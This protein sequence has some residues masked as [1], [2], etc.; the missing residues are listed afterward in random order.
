M[1]Q[2]LKPL[3]LGTSAINTILENNFVYIDKT[4]IIYDM[5]K[6]PNKFF[7]S[8][9]RRFGKSTLLSTINEIFAGNKELFKEQWIYTSP[10]D[11]QTYPI[12]RLDFNI[13]P[14]ADLRYYIKKCLKHVALQYGVF[15]EKS[16]ELDS[17]GIYFRELIIN[18]QAKYKQQV[19]ILVDEYDKPILDVINNMDEAKAKR[20]ILKGLYTIIKGV[21]EKIRFVFLTGV[22]RFSK[23]GIFSGLNNLTDITLSGHY[24]TLCGITQ[25]ELLTYFSHYIEQAAQYLHIDNRSCLEQIKLWYNGFTFATNCVSVYNPYSTMLFLQNKEFNNYWFSSGNPLFLIKL[26]MKN[27]YYL[28]NLQQTSVEPIFFDSFDIDQI[29]LTILLLQTGYL[30]IC[31]T[32]PIK[33]VG[34]KNAIWLTMPNY[35]ISM[36]LNAHILQYIYNSGIIPSTINQTFIKGVLKDELEYFKTSIISLFANIP[37]NWYT[38]NN[39]AHYEGFYCSLFYAFVV[40]MGYNVIAE[41]TTNHGR[42]DLTLIIQN[43]VYIFELKSQ[44]QI[45]NKNTA[46]EQ[47]KSKNYAQKYIGQGY[48]KIYLIGIEFNEKERNLVDFRYE[49]IPSIG[50]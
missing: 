35:E 13:E 16:Y 24:S 43:K 36:S 38:N 25:E 20:E 47:I 29:E 14:D 18:L 45:K 49:Y 32:Q 40:G 33:I 27:R 9:P 37:H 21:D 50:T 19:V 3:P 31:Q 2:E 5:I 44:N 28:P 15:E 34:Y 8:R 17:Y 1:P 39:I 10:W 30:T 12:I 41:D 11:W 48:A 22:T 7:L 42:I 26:L 6:N 46:L 23:V 4:R